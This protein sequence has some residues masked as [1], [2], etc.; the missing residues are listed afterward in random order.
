MK[1]KR[2]KIEWPFPLPR[3]HCGIA[4]GNGLAGA[5]V[6]GNERLNITVNRADFWDR[7]AGH[8]LH[9]AALDCLRGLL[10]ITIRSQD[11]GSH[12]VR[13][14]LSPD[15]PLLWSRIPD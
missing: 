15:M 12:C 7:R 9:S 4:L 1:L 14:A 2:R 3:T 8:K 5:L 11:G 10:A 6:W 13:I